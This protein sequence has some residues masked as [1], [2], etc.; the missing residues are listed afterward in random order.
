M[1]EKALQTFE[2]IGRIPGRILKF[3]LSDHS[4]DFIDDNTSSE[5]R[6]RLIKREEKL[7]CIR[8]AMIGIISGLG[9]VWAT[10]LATPL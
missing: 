3:L 9:I 10:F 4:L 7:I 8:A 6:L 1:T 5:E 2:E